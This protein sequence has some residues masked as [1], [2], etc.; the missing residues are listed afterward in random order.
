MDRD[1]RRSRDAYKRPVSSAQAVSAAHGHGGIHPGLDEPLVL[2][3]SWDLT[4][5]PVE[6]PV[7]RHGL[8]KDQ[9]E[10]IQVG[11]IDTRL[12]EA[13]AEPGHD[14]GVR[15]CDEPVI[16]LGPLALGEQVGL[17]PNKA[18]DLLTTSST[19]GH[20]R[21]VNEPGRA[22]GAVVGN[23]SSKRNAT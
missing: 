15:P 5:H 20:C 16:E 10:R 4:E 3:P 9:R 18:G 23:G 17:T 8:N 6:F 11:S 7:C 1:K 19:F 12:P 14:L 13:G 22:F 21:R 2:D